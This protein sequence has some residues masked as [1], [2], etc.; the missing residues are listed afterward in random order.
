MVTAASSG[1]TTRASWNCEECSATAFAM[2]SR[3]TRSTVIAWYE[4]PEM[5][6]QQPVTNV[7]PSII[8]TSEIFRTSPR[9]WMVS[10]HSSAESA[11]ADAPARSEEHTSELQSRQ[12]LVC[13]L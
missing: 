4:G 8:Q 1:P 5:A 11:S 3:S 2:S 10:V 13:R 7:S 12:Y 9:Q 6:Q